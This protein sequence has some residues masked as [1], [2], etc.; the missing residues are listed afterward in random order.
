MPSAKNAAA[1]SST[2]ECTVSRAVARQRE[3]ERRGARP[4]RGARVP[5]AAAHEL[6]DEC[7]QQD[8]GVEVGGVHRDAVGVPETVVLLHG[9][10]GTGRL[11]D[12]VVAR[13][14]G[15][16]YRPLAPTCA[17]TATAAARAAGLVRRAASRTSW[18]SSRIRSRSCGYSMGGRIAL[19]AALAAPERIERLVLVATT[20][21]IEDAAERAQRRARRRGARR[22]D[23]ARADR[24]LRRPLDGAAAVRRHAAGGLAAAQRPDILATTRARS[25]RLLRG[26]GHRRDASRCG[27]GCSELR[28]P[29]TVVAGERDAKFRALGERLAPALPNARA[30]DRRGRGPRHPARSIRS[31]SPRRSRLADGRLRSALRRP[32]GVRADASA[33][34]IR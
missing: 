5:H 34:L 25:P 11:W 22:A 12:P 24:G 21:G 23:R 8:V 27:T 9:F 16:R 20:A 14:D 1:R 31:A 30:R 3:H 19:H 32:G 33:T 17:A 2:C 10:A 4:R 15:E 6:V 28:M 7:P 13:L 29:A 18:A 26:I